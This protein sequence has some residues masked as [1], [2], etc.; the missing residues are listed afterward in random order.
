M[1]HLLMDQGK[2][3]FPVGSEGFFAVRGWLY[4]SQ[5]APSFSRLTMNEVSETARLDLVF[6]GGKLI[7]WA[8]SPHTRYV[9]SVSLARFNTL[10][11]ITRFTVCQEFFFIGLDYFPIVAFISPNGIIFAW[12]NFNVLLIFNLLLPKNLA[13]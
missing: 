5:A 12:I 7:V 10:S 3:G 8:I 1:H 6:Q 9:R 13:S 11:S 2:A 4:N